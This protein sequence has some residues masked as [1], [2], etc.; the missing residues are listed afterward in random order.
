MENRDRYSPENKAKAKN[1]ESLE[2]S[3]EQKEAIDKQLSDKHERLS[4]SPENTVEKRAE[5]SQEAGKDALEVAKS[6]EKQ[7]LKTEQEAS[8]PERGPI[9][10]L[11]RDQSYKK[12][13]SETRQ[14]MSPA[15]RS[16]SKVIHNK[17][18]EK[19][20]ETLGKTIARPNAILAG[21]VSAFILSLGVYLVA[22]YFG[23]PLSGTETIA[24]FAIGWLIGIL[25]DYLRVMITGRKT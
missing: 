21:G 17:A 19:T 15:S 24:A 2:L 10:K 16:F 9:N 13:M 8:A 12:V 5:N 11:D 4:N 22:R 6:A 1:L 25:Y 18:I 14:H 20:S 7:Q 23:Y 3:A